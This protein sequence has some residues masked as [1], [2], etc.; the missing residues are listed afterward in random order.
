MIG[1]GTRQALRAWQK[2][3]GLPA[4]GYLSLKM[5]GRLSSAVSKS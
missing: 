1:A 2:A 4:D 3:Q 5:V